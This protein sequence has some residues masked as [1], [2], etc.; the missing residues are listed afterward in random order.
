MDQ[1]DRVLKKKGRKRKSGEKQRGWRGN[2]QEEKKNRIG[3]KWFLNRK[4]RSS[5]HLLFN[6]SL[7]PTSRFGVVGCDNIPK[8]KP[9]LNNCT[10]HAYTYYALRHDTDLT[11]LK[12]KHSN[13]I[14]L[15]TSPY[16]PN[17]LFDASPLRIRWLRKVDI[18]WFLIG[19]QSTL[20]TWSF[21]RWQPFTVI[22]IVSNKFPH[23][24]TSVSISV[25]ASQCISIFH[26]SKCFDCMLL[27]QYSIPIW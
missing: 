10:C 26:H 23:I 22:Q 21:I 18:S 6:F 5:G 20:F 17:T 3:T 4:N 13:R 19:W 25:D 15:L 1:L 2:F 16:V 7:R 9:K 27:P 11:V 12:Q 14:I 8:P 24:Q